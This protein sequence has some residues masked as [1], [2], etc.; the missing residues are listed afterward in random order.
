MIKNKKVGTT[1][2]GQIPRI[3]EVF[4]KYY[5]AFKMRNFA[6]E[7]N[8][9]ADTIYGDYVRILGDYCRDHDI[10]FGPLSAEIEQGNIFKNWKKYVKNA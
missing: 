7:M 10:S 2:G 1:F 3:P 8:Q 4:I 9:I 5:R 6:D